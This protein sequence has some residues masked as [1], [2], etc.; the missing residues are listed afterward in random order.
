M[1]F[2]MLF[3]CAQKQYPDI[4]RE[5]MIPGNATKVIPQTDL[6]PPILHSEEYYDPVPLPSAINSRGG[7]DSAFITPDGSSLYFFFTPDVSVPPQVQVLDNVTG[8]W[9]SKKVDGQWTQA[10]RVHLI[11]PGELSLDGCEFVQ[12]DTMWFCS[13]RPGN[14]REIDFYTAEFK[15]GNW[16]DWKNAG[17]ELNVEIGIGEMH[18]SADGSEIYYHSDAGRGKGGIDLYVTEKVNGKWQPAQNLGT[19]NTELNEG[20]PFLTQDGSELWF[21]RFYN[22]TPGIFRSKKV[23]GSWGEPELIISQFAGE[24]SLDNEGNIYF[25]HHFYEYGEMIEADIYIAKKK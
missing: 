19:L 17:K 12:G 23:D 10:T 22:G 13:V 16:T 3:G 14:S 8:I 24:P 25:T 1:L 5:D 21:T 4:T 20:W 11:G 2:L 9:V 15:N 18:M 6:Y 7:E